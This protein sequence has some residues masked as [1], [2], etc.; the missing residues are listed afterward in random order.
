LLILALPLVL[1]IVIVLIQSLPTSVPLV[2][3]LRS[4]T[5]ALTDPTFSNRLAD[6]E[7]ALLDWRR[8]PLI[9]WGPGTFIQF[10]GTRWGTDAWIA[11]QIARTL[12]ETGLLGLLS[13][14]GF[15]AGVLWIGSRPLGRPI[16]PLSRAALL[17]LWV[18]FV[19]LQVAYQSTDGTWLAYM[20]VHAALLVSGARL[21]RQEG[22]THLRS[23]TAFREDMA[24]VARGLGRTA[25]RALR[26]ADAIVAGP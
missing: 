25:Q 9:G 16:D 22:E 14:G 26:R 10:Y 18:G 21:L 13:F 4:L 20:W 23:Q 19:V 17:G 5:T 24:V 6:I 3:R 8:H 11:N 15:L 12:Q 7:Q 1:L 2:T